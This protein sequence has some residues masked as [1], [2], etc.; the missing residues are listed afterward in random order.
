LKPSAVNKIIIWLIVCLGIVLP[1]ATGIG[2]KLYLQ[3]QGEPTLAWSDF[4]EPEAI[5]L[6]LWA[7]PWFAAPYL[8]LALLARWILAGRLPL[9]DRFTDWERRVIVLA[10]LGWGAVGSIRVFVDI[11]MDLD[12]IVFL[13]AFYIPLHYADDMLIGLAAG[14]VI[15]AL[16][17]AIRRCKGVRPKHFT[18]L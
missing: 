3:S 12:L 1:W 13:L 4:F 17:L 11:F 7:T 18:N 2:V 6:E 9:L 5:P 10:S 8:L 16:S 14:I 15:A